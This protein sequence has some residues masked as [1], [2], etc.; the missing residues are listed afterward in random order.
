M[1]VKVGDRYEV[2]PVRGF[3]C[4]EIFEWRETDRRTGKAKEKPGFVSMGKYPST[5]SRAL[6][7]L[8]EYDIKRLEGEVDLSGAVERL[9]DFVAS[10]KVLD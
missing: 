10:A 4:W 9:N 5:I 1:V 6:E 2:R 7:I 3:T 8:A